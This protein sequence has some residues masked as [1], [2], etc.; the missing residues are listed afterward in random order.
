MYAWFLVAETKRKKGALAFLK[1]P[2]FVIILELIDV[3]IISGSWR[4]KNVHTL[5]S[6]VYYLFSDKF[7][8][9]SIAL[10][11]LLRKLCNSL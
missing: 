2:F 10:T 3:A 9:F 8:K 7:P 5:F 4:F 11:F 6:V 1:R